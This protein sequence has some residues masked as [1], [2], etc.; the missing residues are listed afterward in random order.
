MTVAFASLRTLERAENLKSLWDAYDGDKVFIK[1]SYYHP[2]ELNEKKFDLV[3]TDEFLP[4]CISPMIMIYHGIAGG[5]TY[6]LDAPRRYHT[7]ESLKNYRWFITSSEDMVEF[8]AKQS[9]APISKILPLGL[10]R[11]DAYIGKK[12]GD[13]GLLY[14]RTM[15]LHNKTVYLYV[16]TFRTLTIDLTVWEAIDS[17]LDDDEVLLIKRHQFDKDKMIKRTSY[18]HIIEVDPYI[19]STPYLIDCDVVITDYS[20]IMFDAMVLDKPVVL[21]EKDWSSYREQRGMY[22]N[23]PDK[24]STRHTQ[25][26]HELLRL[27]REAVRK[28]PGEVEIY[29]KKHL[30]GACDGNSVERIINLIKSEVGNHGE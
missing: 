1:R 5:K 16:P 21:F 11:T 14:A 12:K 10:P 29:N 19:P 30:A 28:G 13:G 4:E 22:F 2:D 15:P 25:N 27:C 3:I 24:Y 17:W 9:G 8:A 18:K 26:G 6:G 20:S 7:K 23:Y